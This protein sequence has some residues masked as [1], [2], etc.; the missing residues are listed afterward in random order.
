MRL[1]FVGGTFDE[2]GGK[3]SG[4]A[5]RL[6]HNLRKYVDPDWDFREENGGYWAW[7]ER[8]MEEDIKQYDVIIWLANI[9]NDKPKLVEKIK[10]INST[11][12]LVTSKNNMEEKYSIYYFTARMLQLHSNL[13]LEF[14]GNTER[15]A[16]SIY[17]PL[18]NCFLMKQENVVE[19]AEILA[20]RI[21]AL[22]SFSRAASLRLSGTVEVP[23]DE[24]FFALARKYADKFHELVHIENKDRFL[25]NL[26][27]RCEHG[28]PS[29]RK[30]QY[31]YVS[32]RNIDKREI[33]KEG[34]VP[35][36]MSVRDPSAQLG[37]IPY[38]GDYKP[39]VDAPINYLLYERYPNLKYIL[40]SHVYI[41]GIPQTKEAIPC[42]ALEEAYAIMDMVGNKL[43]DYCYINLNGH[44]SI[45]LASSLEPLRNIKYIPREFP[46]MQV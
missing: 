9:G 18:G 1:L 31:F 7:I 4:Y 17:D 36:V 6:A 34:F 10:K 29:F 44:G 35:V 22:L 5:R 15:V 28:F 30:G 45:V 24:E 12:L 8:L 13:M 39:S 19:V 23:D 46:T 38:Y 25:G 14:T 42:G 11:A 2:N 40:H 20:N 16:T 41:E 37:G 27:Y 21:K 3:V 33:T 43:R 26:S 32:R